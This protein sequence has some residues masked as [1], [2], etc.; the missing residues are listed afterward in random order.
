MLSLPTIIAVNGLSNTPIQSKTFK[1]K[2]GEN[3][4]S[5]KYISLI[6]FCENLHHNLI[7]SLTQKIRGYLPSHQ[8]TCICKYS[9]L[10]K[11]VRIVGIAGIVGI[12]I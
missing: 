12:S 6:Q 7:F 8:I 3:E 9:E 4:C 1:K 10:S 5:I 11:G 2:Y